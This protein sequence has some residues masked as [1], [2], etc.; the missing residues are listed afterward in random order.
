M[1]R[2]N[3]TKGDCYAL[4]EVINALLYEDNCQTITRLSRLLG[5]ELQPTAQLLKRLGDD[6]DAIIAQEQKERDDT[7][8]MAVIMQLIHTKG[9]ND[10]TNNT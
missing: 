4:C 6:I 1:S 5:Y 9:H 7:D 8:Q 3:Y 10:E 2:Y